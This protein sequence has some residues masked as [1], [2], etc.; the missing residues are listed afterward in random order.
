MTRFVLAMLVA[1]TVAVVAG[2]A[3]LAEVAPI[4]P[5]GDGLVLNGYVLAKIVPWPLEILRVAAFIGVVALL[6]KWNWTRYMQRAH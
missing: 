6:T 2:L 5:D 3:G 1:V 4:D